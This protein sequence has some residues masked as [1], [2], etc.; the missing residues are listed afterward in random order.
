M[1]EI[2][3]GTTAAPTDERSERNWGLSL[4]TLENQLKR[5][6]AYPV[7]LKLNTAEP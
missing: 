7:K 6:T 2:S 5:K 4:Y 1:R 3:V